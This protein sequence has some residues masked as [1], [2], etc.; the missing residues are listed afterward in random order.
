MTTTSYL[1]LAAELSSEFL[2]IPEE[3][4][5]D[6]VQD[7]LKRII[8]F[9]EADCCAVFKVAD[10]KERI[11]L[12]HEINSRNTVSLCTSMDAKAILPPVLRDILHSNESVTLHMRDEFTAGMPSHQTLL[13]HLHIDSLLLMPIAV[14][15]ASSYLFMLVST[16]GNREWAQTQISQ[17]RLLAEILVNAICRL[18]LQNALQRTARELSE[19]HQIC[20]LGS[21]EWDIDSGK[22]VEVEGIYPI[23]G[24]RPETQEEFMKLVRDSDRN[25]LQRAIAKAATKEADRKVAEYWIRTRKGEKR[26]V[27]SRF[28]LLRS[29]TGSHMVGTI[30]DV[31]EMHCGDQELQILR[32]QQWHS[33]RI[34]HTGVLIASLAHELSQP[35]S[36]TLSNAQ[37]GLHF[38][39]REPLD[40]QEIRET[41]SDI[42]ADS[43]RARA[44]IDALRAMIRREKTKRVPIDATEIMREVLSL[45][46]SEFIAH[47]VEVA[48]DSTTGCVV[49][50][51]K[52]QIEQ[53]LVNLILNSIESMRNQP[54]RQ[55]HLHAQVQR[56]SEE[57]EVQLSVCDTGVGIPEDQIDSIFEAFW[58]TKPQGLGM[59]LAVCR[60]IVEAHGGRIWA[61]RNSDHGV[62]ILFR[63]PAPAQA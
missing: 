27:R 22:I 34:A 4:L 19:A 46:H 12:V 39:S 50:A 54:L 36:A 58:T 1:K 13:A 37:A 60:S 57:R 9:F 38:L 6:A 11:D 41:L 2:T 61:E 17:L 51:D 52:T 55:R 49:F 14:F 47:Q 40:R 23:L 48:F 42:V 35:L 21:W 56:F 5:H 32:S 45:L 31:T 20:K 18:D 10:D 15:P 24:V 26:K 63:L 30:Q 59:G 16:S 3:R 25:H 33:N 29:D 62:T 7:A 53:I 8:A 43:R 44:I 28:E